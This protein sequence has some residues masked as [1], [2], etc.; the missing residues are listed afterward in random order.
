M[1]AKKEFWKYIIGCSH[2]E[3]NNI[4]I[5]M[6]NI[7]KNAKE[8]LL[9]K[10]HLNDLKSMIEEGLF[11]DSASR[12]WEGSVVQLLEEQMEKTKQA[13]ELQKLKTQ[14]KKIKLRANNLL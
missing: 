6:D 5:T 10:F 13:S 14:Y 8:K 12:D 2:E 4:S 11:I 1:I 9:P 7:D 3:Q